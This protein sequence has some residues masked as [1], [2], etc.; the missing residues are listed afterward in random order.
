M[1]RRAGSPVHLG[2]IWDRSGARIQPALLARGLRRIAIE[3][4]VQIR[5]QTPVVEVLRGRPPVLR[6][7]F[8]AVVAEK[9]VLAT[10]AWL[11]ALPEIRRAVLP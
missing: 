4:G 11:C 5:E 9:V 7:P 2:G 8:G 6:T 3:Q 1:A 10:N